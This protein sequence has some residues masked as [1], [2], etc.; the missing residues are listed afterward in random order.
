ME[1]TQKA[2]FKNY[3][4]IADRPAA[5]PLHQTCLRPKIT[6][7]RSGTAATHPCVFIRPEER[8]T[9]LLGGLFSLLCKLVAC[10]WVFEYISLV[11]LGKFGDAC[12]CRDGSSPSSVFS[13]RRRAGSSQDSLQPASR[14]QPSEF[15]EFTWQHS[16]V[17]GLTDADVMRCFFIFLKVCFWP[18][19]NI[20]SFAVFIY[21]FK[22][23]V[24]HKSRHLF[25]WNV[26]K[27]AY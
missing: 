14:T 13:S 4:T 25:A 6:R 8:L 2:L 22:G 26:N 24:C 3:I 19:N 23:P 16:F 20:L 12:S 17:R 27:N 11:R 9:P 15:M 1:I 10:W 21:K 18:N 7:A 5:L